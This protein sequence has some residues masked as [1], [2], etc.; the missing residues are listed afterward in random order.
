MSNA[1]GDITQVEGRL[2]V[3]GSNVFTGSSPL[4]AAGGWVRIEVSPVQEVTTGQTIEL[5]AR[6]VDGADNTN[7][8]VGYVGYYTS[9]PLS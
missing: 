5:Q 1:V 9:N 4:P 2:R 8:A 3:D 6:R 7:E